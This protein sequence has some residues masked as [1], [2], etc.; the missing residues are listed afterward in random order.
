M[1]SNTKYCT[2]RAVEEEDKPHFCILI[3]LPPNKQTASLACTPS[4][5]CET[6][7]Q[8][9]RIFDVNLCKTKCKK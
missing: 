2:P 6:Q 9:K 5:A 4:I 3:F 1:I 8:Q 7:K